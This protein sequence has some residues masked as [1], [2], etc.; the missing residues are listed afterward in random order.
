MTE[1]QFIQHEIA[2]W[3]EDYIYDLLDRG[4]TPVRVFNQEGAI[5]WTWILPIKPKVAA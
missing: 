2:T 1:D 3:G 4:Y 5:K